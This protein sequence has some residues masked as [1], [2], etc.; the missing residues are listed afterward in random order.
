MAD[1]RV[2]ALLE[3]MAGAALLKIERTVFDAKDRPVEYISILYRSDRYHYTVDLVRKK[4]Q[5]KH[6]WDDIKV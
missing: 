5:S 2:G 1:S 3:V 6:R 4:S